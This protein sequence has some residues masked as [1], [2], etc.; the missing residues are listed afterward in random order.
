MKRYLK[1]LEEYK[2]RDADRYITTKPERPSFWLML[3]DCL[4]VA[5]VITVVFSLLSWEQASEAAEL[6]KKAAEQYSAMLAE[7]LN[8]NALV[9]MKAKKAYFCGKAIEVPV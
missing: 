6:H 3:L 1:N 9:D 2:L 7:C 8:G 4:I 5:L